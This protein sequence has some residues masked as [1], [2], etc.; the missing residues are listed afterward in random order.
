MQPVY[1]ERIY[2][3][4][5][6]GISDIMA[7]IGGMNAF[8]GPLLRALIPYFVVLFLYQLA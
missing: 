2:T 7:G 1:I 6:Y 4:K 3:Y 5:Y 8:V